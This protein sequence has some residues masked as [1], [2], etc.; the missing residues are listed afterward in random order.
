MEEDGKHSSGKK[1]ENPEEN[2][3]G[4]EDTISK[5]E[6]DKTVNGLVEQ[7][8]ELRKQK[9]E[10]QEQLDS[11]GGS[12]NGSEDVEEKV[13]NILAEEKK[14][15][16]KLN[17]ERAWSR[18]LE[19]N[20]EFNPENDTSGLR[21]NAIENSLSRLNVSSSYS[22]EDFL[23]NLE[24][25]KKLAFGEKSRPQE[26]FSSS[27]SSQ[28]PVGSGPE[29]RSQAKLTPEQEELRKQKGWTPEKY[30]EMKAKYPRTI[31]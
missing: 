31:L 28:P 22:E 12:G 18:F 27:D 10:L 3:E 11:K 26:D 29:S 24:D 30:L 20:K 23:R 19:K 5:G 1:V 6:H 9:Q 14:A 17:R 7:V 13:R 4:G 16:A 25:A 8:K 15:Q 21:K 2:K